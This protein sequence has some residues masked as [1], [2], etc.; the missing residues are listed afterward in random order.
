MPTARRSLPFLLTRFHARVSHILVAMRGANLRG[1]NEEIDWAHL[2]GGR[3][4]PGHGEGD[5]Q[6]R[7][8]ERKA[9]DY[10]RFGSRLFVAAHCQKLKFAI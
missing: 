5:G 10:Y 6:L 2:Q 4:I 8:Q 1:V 9:L 3:F 7:R